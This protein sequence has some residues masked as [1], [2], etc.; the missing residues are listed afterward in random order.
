[1]VQD[2]VAWFH[3]HG[4][5]VPISSQTVEVDKHHIAHVSDSLH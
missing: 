5:Q 1:M 3:D 2:G 4:M